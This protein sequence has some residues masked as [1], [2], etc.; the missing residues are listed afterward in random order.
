MRGDVS[1][2]SFWVDSEGGRA[3]K[4]RGSGRLQDTKGLNVGR[5]I[6]IKHRVFEGQCL[7]MLDRL[8]VNAVPW[9]GRRRLT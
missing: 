7:R 2:E 3:L 8:G 9:G 5:M 6:P 1:I 4:E